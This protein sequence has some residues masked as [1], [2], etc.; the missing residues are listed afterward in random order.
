[1]TL[2]KSVAETH[3]KG[4]EMGVDVILEDIWL[5]SEISSRHP[6]YVRRYVTD[7]FVFPKL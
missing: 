3:E 1:M 5:C 2:V 4:N 6:E 7:F